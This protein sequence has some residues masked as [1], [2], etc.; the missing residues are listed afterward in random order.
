MDWGVITGIS[1]VVI[2]MCAVLISIWHGIETRRH[3]RLSVMPH[4]TTWTYSSDEKQ[5]Y[6]V[7]LINN[8]IGPA[9]IESFEIYV[10]GKLISG[11]G[12]GPIKKALKILFPNCNYEARHS[13]VAKGY[14][15]APNE[16]CEIAAIKFT[17]P[18]FPSQ[19][20][21]DESF[22]RGDIRVRYKSFYDDELYL[23]TESDQT[24]LLGSAPIST[25]N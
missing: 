25:K 1:S 11:V 5:T 9:L 18:P 23:S 8:G 12:T 14:S 24:K 10:D 21:I 4:L 19:E 22:D 16:R 17:E 15:M 3:N 2:A 20:S 13:F 6:T 7:E